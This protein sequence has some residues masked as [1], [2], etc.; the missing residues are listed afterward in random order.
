MRQNL[1]ILALMIA[2]SFLVIVNVQA[3]TL[4]DFSQWEQESGS[5][6]GTLN[7]KR[8]SLNMPRYFKEDFKNLQYDDVNILNDGKGNPWLAFNTKIILDKLANGEYSIRQTQK[9]LFESLNGK[10]ILVKDFSESVN[11]D[12]DTLDF[13]KEEYSLEVISRG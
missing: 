3:Q 1:L 6:S 11:V 10:W 8:V 2:F 13:L 12:K 9:F 5:I 4:P 7:G